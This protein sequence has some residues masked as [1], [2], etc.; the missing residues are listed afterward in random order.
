MLPSA[1]G[2]GILPMTNPLHRL[3]ADATRGTPREESL[4]SRRC[5]FFSSPLFSMPKINP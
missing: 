4:R 2:I 3:E 1:S 5:S